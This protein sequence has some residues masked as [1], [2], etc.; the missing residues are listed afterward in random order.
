MVGY[1]CTSMKKHGMYSGMCLFTVDVRV[2]RSCQSFVDNAMYSG[3][4]G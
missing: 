1:E 3:N 4:V 2:L